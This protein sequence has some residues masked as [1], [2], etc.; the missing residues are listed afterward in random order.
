MDAPRFDDLAK[1]LVSFASRR[2]LLRAAAAAAVAAPLVRSG[3]VAARG[4]CH[5][6]VPLVS[7]KQCPGPDA[8]CPGGLGCLCTRTTERKRKCL[9]HTPGTCPTEPECTRSRDCAPDLYCARLGECCGA[10]MRRCL[11]VCPKEA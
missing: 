10:G 7:D 1:S 11:P 6:G 4:R 2:H 8:E 5:K 3:A 9:N